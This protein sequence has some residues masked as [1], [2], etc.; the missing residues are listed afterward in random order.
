MQWIAEVAREE[1]GGGGETGRCVSGFGDG[2]DLG[3]EGYFGVGNI[4]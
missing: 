2:T 4:C 3:W 1:K